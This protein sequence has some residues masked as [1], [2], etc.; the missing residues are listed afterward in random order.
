MASSDSSLTYAQ[1]SGNLIWR[2]ETF[3]NF[4]DDDIQEEEEAVEG[5]V[6]EADQWAAGVDIHRQ[7]I[8]SR[9]LTREER[10]QRRQ[11]IKAQLSA[12]ERDKRNRVGKQPGAA[13]SPDSEGRRLAQWTSQG[14]R[15]K[16]L[17]TLSDLLGGF[18]FATPTTVIKSEPEI[19]DDANA[20]SSSLAACNI[21]QEKHA[22]VSSRSGKSITMRNNTR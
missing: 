8:S 14:Q 4:S 2:E 17:D 12:P 6:K 20:M 10:K 13:A 16:A 7:R 15:G 21:R 1:A 9:A 3:N 19:S 5:V 22:K 18:D 11:L